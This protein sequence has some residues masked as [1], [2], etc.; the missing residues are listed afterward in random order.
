MK[1]VHLIFN[2]HL[3]PIWLWP[4]TA[5]LDETLATC[6]SACDRL[7]AHPDLTFARGEAWVY[8]QV[9]RLDP[10][11]FARIRAHVASGRWEIV[12]GWWIQPDCNAPSGWGMEKQIALGRDYFG[13]KFGQFPRIA[14]NVDS[15]GHAATLPALMRAAGQDRYIMMRPQE[16]EK[17]LPARL[18]HWRGYEGG[19]EVTAF[20]LAGGYLSYPLH[21]LRDHVRHSLTELP[22]GVTDTLCFV[23]L[24]DHGGGPTEALIARCRELMDSSLDLFEGA[25]LIFSTPSRFFAA[26][27]GQT[28]SLPLVTG[29]LQMHAVGCYSVYRPVKLGVRRG[30]HLLRQAE[31]FG[32]SPELEEAWKRVCFHQFHDTLGGT[33]LPSAYV[34]VN[35]QLGYAA[36]IADEALHYGLRRQM[37]GLGDDPHQRVVLCNASDAPWD[38][39]AEYEPWVDW[40]NPLHQN[41]ALRDERGQTVACQ[42]VA[43]EA[44]CEFDAHGKPTRLLLRLSAGPGEMRVFQIVRGE[45]PPPATPGG[46]VRAADSRLCDPDLRLDL[47]EDFTDT[48]SHGIDRYGEDPVAQSAWDAPL[49]LDDGPLMAAVQR[50][51]RIGESLLKAE[52]RVYA[53]EPYVELLLDVHWL[54]ARKVLKLTLPLASPLGERTDGILGGQLVRPNDGCERPLRDW[55]ALGAGPDALGIVCPDVFALDAMPGR[56][57]LTLL[58][59][60]PLAFHDPYAGPLARSVMSDH[61][62]HRFRFRFFRGQPAAPA[63]LEGDALM[64]QR[65]LIVADLTRGMPPDHRMP[66][67]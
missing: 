35:D 34:Q 54:E 48:W 45:T 61:G 26:I 46:G 39:Y 10:E 49:V 51:G 66:P 25:R 19:P 17:A 63:R 4:W 23:G 7:D 24:G 16:Y 13:E 56:V 67:G 64:L 18:F 38:G 36:A 33:C 27:A 8:A 58:R 55:T 21:D 57:R 12:G 15:F 37:R 44:H 42:E 1:T 22:D 47:I 59:A 29:E 60:V 41:F 28:P 9:E 11:L 30:E 40:W 6:R 50:T 3:D 53:G 14:M 31:T 52:W 32:P 5:G 43:S 65:P 20:R 62:P 2:A